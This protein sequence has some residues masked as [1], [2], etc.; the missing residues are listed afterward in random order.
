[1]GYFSKKLMNFASIAEIILRCYR[2]LSYHDIEVP[3]VG[4]LGIL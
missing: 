2:I 4:Q 1:M 3:D